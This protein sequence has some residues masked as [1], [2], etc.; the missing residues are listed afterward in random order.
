MNPL[1]VKS[2]WNGS[3][4]ILNVPSRNHFLQWSRWYNISALMNIRCLSKIPFSEG[5]STTFRKKSTGRKS[6]AILNVLSS[7]EGFVGRDPTRLRPTARI[8]FFRL[9][10]SEVLTLATASPSALRQIWGIESFRLTFASDFE[11]LIIFL[12]DSIPGLVGQP[13]LVF[14]LNVLVNRSWWTVPSHLKWAL[15]IVHRQV[16]FFSA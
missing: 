9:G 10:R 15:L 6:S 14:L 8:M 16:T 2:C 5:T 3:A 13:Q 11:S 12:C 4:T 1:I 7:L